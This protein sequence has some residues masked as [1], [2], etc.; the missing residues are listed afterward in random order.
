MINFMSNNNINVCTDAIVDNNFEFKRGDITLNKSSSKDLFNITLNNSDT[1]VIRPEINSY[2]TYVINKTNSL[3]I[4]V[5]NIAIKD[6]NTVN[7]L[8]SI[9]RSIDG[10][11]NKPL[12]LYKGESLEQFIVSE[13]EEDHPVYTTVE[14]LK[15]QVNGLY[16]IKATTDGYTEYNYTWLDTEFANYLKSEGKAYY[17]TNYLRN[18]YGADFINDLV[19]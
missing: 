12:S 4:K 19:K 9:G 8:V 1:L 2:S 7:D 15:T 6:S 13:D 18:D 5:P 17:S 3:N 10:L 16:K 14:Y 11:K